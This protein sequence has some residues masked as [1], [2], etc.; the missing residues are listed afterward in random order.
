MYLCQFFPDRTFALCQFLGYLDLNIDIEIAAF[1]RNAR[2]TALAQ[3]KTLPTL[4]SGRNF[5]P[6]FAFE[7]WHHQRASQHRLPR[8]D[9]DLMNQIAALDGKIGMPRQTNPQE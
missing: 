9:F 1:A 8:R 3:T 6:H 4:C 7:S 5:Q 2:K